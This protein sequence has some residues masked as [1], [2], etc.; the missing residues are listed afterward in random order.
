VTRHPITAFLLLVYALTLAVVLTPFSEEIGGSLENV[1]GV[2]V[3]AFLVVAVVCGA[4]GVRDLLRRCLRWRVPLRWYAVALALPLLV[5]VLAT[6]LHGQ[7]PLRALADNWSVLFTS[8]LPT[9]ALMLALF[10]L[11]EESGATGFLFA[12]LQDRHGTMRAVLL[13]TVFFWLWHVP[14]TVRDSDTLM[15][16][17][18][19]LAFYLVGHLTSRVLAGWLYNATG[20]S[21]LIVGIFHAMFNA[22][23]NAT[24]FGV[25]VLG[26]P[27]VDVMLMSTG[28]LALA[29]AV[30]TIATRGSL[31]RRGQ[32][33]PA[34]TYAR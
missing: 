10:S 8:F 18:E 31:G 28:V 32:P 15:A 2:A 17:A 4:G 7:A 6:V 26:L 23:V 19:L 34:P 30:V 11:P 9:F 29:A 16:A 33:R 22:T 14:S 12:R 24:G 3:P 1:V 5:L 27:Q 25:A 13:T 20:G 21:V